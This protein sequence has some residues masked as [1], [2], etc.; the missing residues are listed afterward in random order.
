MKKTLFLFVFTYMFSLPFVC[1]AQG[2]VQRSIASL[3][4]GIGGKLKWKNTDFILFTANGNDAKYLQNGRR[5]LID[6]K[7]NKCRFEGKTVDGQNLVVL[8]DYKSG[9]IFR[10]YNNKKEVAKNSPEAQ[11][12]FQKINEQFSKDAALLFLPVFID[13]PETKISNV[14]V[15]IYNA[16][17]LQSLSFQLKD[18]SLTGDI[19]FNAESG[20][21]KQLVDNDGNEYNVNGYKDIGG[22]LMLP[23]TFSHAHHANRNTSFTTVAAFTDIETDKFENL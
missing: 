15:K 1:Q 10:Y 4:K 7:T 20:Y 3:W 16:E 17:K 6:K 9:K 2:T 21:I 11:A 5:F 14:G 13:Q 18:N 19:L 8:F 12:A 22:G 23:T